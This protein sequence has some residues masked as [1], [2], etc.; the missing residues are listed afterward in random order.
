MTT[1]SFFTLR[2]TTIRRQP[3]PTLKDSHFV[4]GL[5]RV[6]DLPTDIPISPLVASEFRWLDYAGQRDVKRALLN[7]EGTDNTFHLKYPPIEIVAGSADK[8]KT[9]DNLLNVRLDYPYQG[10]I[11]GGA[12]YDLI[13]A[14]RAELV[15]RATMAL[16]DR[17]LQPYIPVE[18]ITG[19]PDDADLIEEII[20]ARST[21]LHIHPLDSLSR[22]AP[23]LLETL[24]PYQSVIATAS[25]Q[26]AP[27]DMRDVVYWLRLLLP[28]H[29]LP[30]Q[31][32][33]HTLTKQGAVQQFLAAP[34][35]FQRATSLIPGLLQLHDWLMLTPDLLGLGYRDGIPFVDG[36]TTKPFV[37]PFISRQSHY[38]LSHHALMPALVAL[39]A[40]VGEREGEYSWTLPPEQIAK[41]W[42]TRLA[43]E[44]VNFSRVTWKES[45]RLNLYSH[46]QLLLAYFR[47]A[48]HT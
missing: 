10:I 7:E 19:L 18:I 22:T 9:D 26:D 14:I 12:T 6:V 31:E 24:A 42:Q 11:D 1:S 36:P 39:G 20:A 47:I 34:E 15:D 28:S 43:Q 3:N 8:S 21:T 13:Q 33:L 2:M 23:W 38:A 37:L 44:V 41:I 16:A 29:V 48:A 40:F 45:N 32:G 17:P 35:F 27:Y 30:V 25:S 46:W 5:C 4:R